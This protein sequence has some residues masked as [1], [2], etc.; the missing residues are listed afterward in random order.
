MLALLLTRYG[1]AFIVLGTLI[2][3]ETVLVVGGFAARRGYLSLP[4]VIAAAFAGSLA[5]DQLYFHVA[6][7]YGPRLLEKH[8]SWR[9]RVAKVSGLL[10]RH[11]TLFILTFR[12]VYGM[13]TVSPV[14]VGLTDI[15]ASRFLLLNTCGAALWA[16]SFGGAGY[17]F[18][19]ALEEILGRIEHEEA[20]IFALL[21]A[22][23]A[24]TWLV[25]RRRRH[26]TE[27]AGSL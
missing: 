4:W 15:S 1:Y 3:G 22:V 5:G 17:L 6:R 9:R 19:T 7:R 12:F 16:V 24:G 26:A 2:E 11:S 20:L 18:G 10:H 21:A 14:A 13:R 23:G 25:R 27:S 8:P